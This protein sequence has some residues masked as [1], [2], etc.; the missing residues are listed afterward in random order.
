MRWQFGGACLALGQQIYEIC[1]SLW[2]D[3]DVHVHP[4]RRRRKW[5]CIDLTTERRGLKFLLA[6]V[7][8]WFVPEL[9]AWQSFGTAPWLHMFP[10]APQTVTTLPW[11]IYYRCFGLMDV[12]PESMRSNGQT[13]SIWS[14]SPSPGIIEGVDLLAP[15]LVRWFLNSL[16]W[17]ERRGITN[18][19][20][21]KT[22][23]I[24]LYN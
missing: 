18:A 14:S 13:D 9:M 22:K 15:F 1:W 2:Y 20:S 11:S 23:M 5:L 10:V 24:I 3:T 12:F 4:Q 21:V 17:P 16:A 6:P 8:V 19:A 7:W